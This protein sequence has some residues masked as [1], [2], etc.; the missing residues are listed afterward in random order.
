MAVAVGR[1]NQRVGVGT[2]WL[3]FKEMVLTAIIAFCTGHETLSGC[4]TKVPARRKT[5]VQPQHGCD[6]RQQREG[7][8]VAVVALH[9]LT[10]PVA[11]L[12]LRSVSRAPSAVPSPS[13]ACAGQHLQQPRD[14]PGT[15]TF[16][17]SASAS[18][19]QGALA[20]ASGHR[21]CHCCGRS[22]TLRVRRGRSQ[23][24]RH[25]YVP[26]CVAV[27]PMPELA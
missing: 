2:E 22:A 18:G 14:L 12:L 15:H 20:A 8:G 11:F 1:R 17:C 13:L 10:T 3:S 24:K 23:K 6:D 5:R 19:P 16:A 26:L 25:G 9:P 7:E 21:C 4:Y 27:A